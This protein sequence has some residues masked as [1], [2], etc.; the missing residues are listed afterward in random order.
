[1][2][3]VRWSRSRQMW[4]LIVLCLLL[5]SGLLLLIP[6]MTRTIYWRVVLVAGTCSAIAIALF[7]WWLRATLRRG[8][9]TTD[10]L[11][12]ISSGDLS[13]TAADIKRSTRAERM[14]NALRGLVANLERTIR[15][16]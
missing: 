12:R 15:R 10:L 9:S 4:L 14:A 2:S 3:F 6:D 13:P 16:F 11:N 1:M 7:E 8:Q 5:F